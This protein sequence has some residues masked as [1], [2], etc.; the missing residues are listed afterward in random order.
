MIPDSTGIEVVVSN[1]QRRLRINGRKVA[2]IAKQALA[3]TGSRRFH[4][5]I[6]LVDDA[7]IAKLNSQYHKT[8]GPTDILSFDYGEGQGELIISVEHAVA[9]ARQYRTTPAR[10]LALYVVHGIL[11]LHGYDDRTAPQR[12]R[13]RAAERRLTRRMGRCIERNELISRASA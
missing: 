3:L 13:M 4:L 5:G 6:A 12:R 9:Q 1:R 7:T 11:H 8:P 10:E 2:G